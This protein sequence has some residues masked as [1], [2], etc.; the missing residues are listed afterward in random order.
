MTSSR[1]GWNRERRPSNDAYVRFTSKPVYAVLHAVYRLLRLHV[2]VFSPVQKLVERVRVDAEVRIGQAKYYGPPLEEPI[3]SA[4]EDARKAN[5][6]AS[7]PVV[8]EGL[9]RDSFLRNHVA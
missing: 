1:S 7:L 4:Q 8:S 5:P 9:A 2:N 3:S 6:A